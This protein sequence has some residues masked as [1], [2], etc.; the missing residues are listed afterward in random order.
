MNEAE[1]VSPPRERQLRL[2]PASQPLVTRF[3]PEF[4]RRLPRE[5][6]V[7]LMRDEGDR[8]IYV[9]KA[10]NLRQRLNSYRYPALASRKTVRLVHAVRRIDWEICPSPEEA[11][12]RENELLRT[13]RPRFNYVGTWPHANCFV[14]LAEG[15]EGLRLSL[16]R[17]APVEAPSGL[18]PAGAWL[19]L[20]QSHSPAD[21]VGGRPEGRWFGA[22]KPGAAFAFGALLR[23]LWQTAHRPPELNALPRRLV[24][25]KPPARFDF[26][27]PAT[28]EWFEP[29]CAFLAGNSTQLIESL[30]ARAPAFETVFERQAQQAD[31]ELL[32]QFF[33]IGPR[34]NRELVERTRRGAGLILQDELDDLRILARSVGV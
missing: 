25:E 16:T 27:A 28:I 26:N 2:L 29:L 19:E 30:A 6:G 34:R 10:K 24:L 12:L 15:G 21:D 33:L 20:R 1:E 9:G 23:L 32:K 13:H 31:L 5:P 11:E 18:P 8:L 3:G 4:F 14:V 7:Y 22:F 17:R